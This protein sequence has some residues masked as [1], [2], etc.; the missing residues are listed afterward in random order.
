MTALKTSKDTFA[1]AFDYSGIGI[2]LI[3]PFGKWL[4]VNKAMC[5]LTG[6]TKE[7]LLELSYPDITYIDDRKIDKELINQMLRQEITTYTIEKRFVSKKKKIILA[8]LTLSLVWNSDD[9]PKF[10][11]AQ[12]VDITTKKELENEIK[13][14]NTELEATRI[15]FIN[16]IHQLEELNHIIAHNLRGPAGNINMLSEA[17]LAQSK[18]GAYAKSNPLSNAFTQEEALGFIRDSSNSLMNSL[19]TLMQISEIKLNMD[20]PYNDCDVTATINDITAQ[21][22]N[23]IYEKH[24]VI[25]SDIQVK[26]ARYPKAYLESILYNLISN[27]LKYSHDDIAPEIII[28]TRLCNDRVQIIV[29]DNGIGIDLMKYGDRVFNLNGVFHDGYDSKGVGLY[30]TKTH[31][32][33]FGGSIEVHSAPNEGSEFIV[34]I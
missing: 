30:I 24:A 28:T 7:E 15:S 34:T 31:V 19:Q 4:D 13:R 3:S 12:A 8:S 9:T 20:V 27:A 1:S 21:L 22:Y 26:F 11:I 29:K 33:S 2:A 6:Y 10:F 25:K 32:E 16:K 14:K 23:I 5:D 17:L 18:G